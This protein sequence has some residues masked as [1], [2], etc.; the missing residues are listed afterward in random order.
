M[1]LKA[2]LY[3]FACLS[4]SVVIGGAVYEHLAVVPQ[5]S[6]APP[7]SL[8][9]FQGKYGL[10]AAA[11]WIP[12]HPV[13]LLLLM[14]VL[15]S[16]WKT[17]SRKNALI[18]LTGYMIVVGITAAYFVPELLAITG[19]AFSETV[20]PSLTQRAKLWELMSLVRLSVLVGLAIVLF[21]GLTRLHVKRATPSSHAGGLGTTAKVKAT[22]QG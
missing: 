18:T 12:I 21:L 16:A 7:V 3:A 10:N 1:N 8:S 17:D 14:G 19:T 2:I 15:V 11:F 9:M 4:F 13:T 5:W 6:A 20:D 22:V